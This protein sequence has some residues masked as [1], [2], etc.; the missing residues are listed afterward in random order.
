M[1]ITYI[2]NTV[3]EAI[4]QYYEYKEKE[5]AEIIAKYDFIVGSEDLKNRLMDI[6]PDGA[7]IIYSKY[8]PNPTMFYAVKKF[9]IMD[10]V[11]E[12]LLVE[13]EGL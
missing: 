8:I 4:R 2:N 1:N 5:L 11:K 3:E 12:P 13:S 10:L 6:L 9:D 7:N